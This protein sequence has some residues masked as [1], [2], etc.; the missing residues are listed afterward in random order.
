MVRSLARDRTPDSLLAKHRQQVAAC[1]DAVQDHILAAE[2]AAKAA[3]ETETEAKT[4]ADADADFAPL[5]GDIVQAIAAALSTGDKIAIVCTLSNGSGIDARP[6]DSAMDT[7]FPG[8]LI[9]S[10]YVLRAGL[11][12]KSIPLLLVALTAQR[13]NLTGLLKP[14]VPKGVAL[15]LRLFWLA[16]GCPDMR[17]AFA[18]RSKD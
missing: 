14:L 18:V 15:V 3:A 10:S 1:L 16:M 5:L 8:W 13:E 9:D 11:I 4:R 12:N 2:A 6:Y 17:S 7:N